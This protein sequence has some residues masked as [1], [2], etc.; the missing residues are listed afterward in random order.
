MKRSPDE[1]DLEREEAW[2]GDAVLAL[3][4]REWILREKGKIDGE[5]F[6]NFTTND[7]LRIVG[8]P[9]SVEAEIGRIYQK[10]GLQAGF[11]HVETK[12][13]PLFLQREKVRNR[14]AARR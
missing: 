6:I 1:M 3:F 8:N 9:T 5:A 12:L 11:D 4:V 13:L 14:Q 7:F 10:G 2:V